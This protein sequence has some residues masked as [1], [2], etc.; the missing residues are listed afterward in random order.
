M[1]LWDQ[2]YGVRD[3]GWERGSRIFLGSHCL[4]GQQKHQDVCQDGRVVSG[5]F[6]SHFSLGK[7]E[8][9]GNLN[10][11]TIVLQ[12]EKNCLLRSKGGKRNGQDKQAM[13]HVKCHI[14]LPVAPQ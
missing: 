9:L 2:S 4:L 5:S 1:K 12:K 13:G 3:E 6:T 14:S 8:V 10:M 11:W 7:A